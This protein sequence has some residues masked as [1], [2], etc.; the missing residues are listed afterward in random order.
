[1]ACGRAGSF[2]RFVSRQQV[3]CDAAATPLATRRRAT[4]A[5]S[6]TS[7]AF[8]PA[9][10]VFG[11]AAPFGRLDADAA[12]RP[13][14]S[15]RGRRRLEL[16]LTPWRASCSPALARRGDLA[17]AD[18]AAVGFILDPA[19][20]RLAV[21]ACAGAPACL[22]GDAPAQADAA[23]LRWPRQPCAGRRIAL[24][25]SGCAKGCATR[26]R[27]ASRWSA[28]TGGY[29]LVVDGGAG[30]TRRMRDAALSTEPRPQSL[31]SMRAIRTARGR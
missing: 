21:A 11:A 18:L 28:A 25:V 13:R 20:P 6:W 29:D 4:F 16:R 14:A 1:M 22:S 31:R 5:A 7:R 30:A 10:R 12:R 27:A 3:C 26:R 9:R 23:G 19:D 24:H 2:R 17:A 15:R 8:W